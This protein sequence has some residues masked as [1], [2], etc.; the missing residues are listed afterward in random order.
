V[1]HESDRL[2]AGYDDLVFAKRSS[3]G[4]ARALRLVVTTVGDVPRSWTHGFRRAKSEAIADG[5]DDGPHRLMTS[6]RP[7]CGAG[8]ARAAAPVQ[9]FRRR[10]A[11]DWAPTLRDDRVGILDVGETLIDESS[12][13]ATLGLRQ[14][15]TRR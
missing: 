9:R 8:H 14:S 3:S 10:R 13:W 12:V 5:N 4:S 2:A 7:E 15:V 6:L 11:A 1:R